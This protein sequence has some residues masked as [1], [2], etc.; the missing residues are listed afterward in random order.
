MYG[1]RYAEVAMQHTFQSGGEA[2]ILGLIYLGETILYFF[3][4]YYLFGFAGR[5]IHAVNLWNENEMN[6]AFLK[7][8]SHYKY[9]GIS[10]IVLIS[11]YFLFFL[12]GAIAAVIA[13]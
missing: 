9:V 7:L 5:M 11:L 3:P 4:L 8:K 13:V 10:S 2:F 12:I 1:S 6:A